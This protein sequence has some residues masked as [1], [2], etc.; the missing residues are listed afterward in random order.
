MN[1]RIASRFRRVREASRLHELEVEVE[2]SAVGQR[3]FSAISNEE[4]VRVELHEE[5][6]GS[7]AQGRD[8][9]DLRVG[10]S[11]RPSGIEDQGVRSGERLV[12]QCGL[13]AS[14][15]FSSRASYSPRSSIT[16]SS[17]PSVSGA[18]RPNLGIAVGGSCRRVRGTGSSR[19]PRPPRRELDLARA[20][21]SISDRAPR[22]PCGPVTN[23]SRGSRSPV[24]LVGKSG[25][26]QA[27]WSAILERSSR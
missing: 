12:R 20:P 8:L 23:V 9:L 17:A 6:H 5:Y 4:R 26:P 15:A 7:S 14:R 18:A 1:R 19:C 25:A 13:P 22:G 24:E 27:G 3:R 16:T 11:E 21:R 10:L 2:K